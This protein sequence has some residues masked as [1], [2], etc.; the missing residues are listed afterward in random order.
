MRRALVT[1]ATGLVGRHIVDHLLENGWHVRALVRRMTSA[2]DLRQR[3]AELQLG[4][5]LDEASF[6]VAASGCD[7]IFHAAS[8]GSA[9]GDWEAVR[10]GYVDGTRN[11]IQAA[12]YASARLVHISSVAVYGFDDFV[13]GS[14]E[15]T[16]DHKQRRFLNGDRTR[17]NASACFPP[18]VTEETPFLPLHG[19]AHYA[20]AKRECDDLVLVSHRAG[21]IWATS[22]RPALVY[23][24]HDRHF[25][26]RLARMI[27]FGIVPL[28]AGGRSTLPA[29]HAANVAA[30]VVN[31][32]VTEVAGGRAYN[33][34]NDYDVSVR[35]FMAY[36]AEGLGI[37]AHFIPFPTWAARG[38]I[39]A[40]RAVSLFMPAGGFR[41]PRDSSIAIFA[42]RS[43][44]I[45]LVAHRTAR[46]W[47]A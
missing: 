40:T 47:C 12:V 29:V 35:E 37:S 39:R 43:Q 16:R 1:G 44:R 32:A 22:L 5:V 3:G 25:V 42:P 41:A 10:K 28:F 24:P 27:R 19:S 8:G 9:A 33:L 11:A 46:C 17:Y 7:V 2:V 21:K 6:R 13:G 18:P 23:G 36:A 45:E 34:A 4:D 38:V 30:G 15:A 20:W 31:A 14:D 26:P